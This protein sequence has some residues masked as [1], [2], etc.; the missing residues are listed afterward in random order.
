MTFF[1]LKF[2]LKLYFILGITFFLGLI[3]GTLLTNSWCNED[4]CK[5]ITLKNIFYKKDIFK[6]GVSQQLQEKRPLSTFLIV[7]IFS[8]PAN[9]DRRDVIRSTWLKTTYEILHFFVI[10]TASLSVL[11]QQELK[12]ENQINNDLILLPMLKDYYVEL[13]SKLMQSMIWLDSNINFKFVI[14]VDD[15]SFAQVDL[16]YNTLSSM[17]NKQRLYWGFFDGRSRVKHRGQWKEENWFLCDY[18]LPYARGGGYVLSSDLV[19]FV[20]KNADYLQLYNSEDVSLGVWL[21]PL[22]IKRIHDPKF[23]TEFQSRG[24]F[25]TYL[26]THKQNIQQIMEKH[27]N[28]VENGKLCSRE[29]RRRISYI[30]NWKSAPSQ[31][32]IRNDSSIP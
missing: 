29:F 22:N 28:L 17:N 15:D 14:K 10:G 31:C 2:N 8:S 9:K 3:L 4:C 12:E 6:K 16:I 23:D 30:Y 18:Y 1:R 5:E 11:K 20:A 13:T 27:K 25:N 24:C 7:I 32:C 21:S 19:H 26:I